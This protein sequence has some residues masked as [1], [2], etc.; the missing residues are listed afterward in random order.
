MRAGDAAVYLNNLEKVCSFYSFVP[1]FYSQLVVRVSNP[2]DKQALLS[3]SGCLQDKKYRQWSSSVQ[4]LLAPGW[5]NQLKCALFVC[6]FHLHLTLILASSLFS[7]SNYFFHYLLLFLFFSTRDAPQI[8][9]EESVSASDCG[10]LGGRG[11][12]ARDRG[13]A[14]TAAKHTHSEINTNTDNKQ[15]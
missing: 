2:F 14:G 5:P 15:K 13:G 9:V 1:L 11:D 3:F 8:R 7:S 4:E 12:A 10:S 6:L